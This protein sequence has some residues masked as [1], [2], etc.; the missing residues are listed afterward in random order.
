M[1][2]TRDRIQSFIDTLDYDFARFSMHEFVQWLNRRRGREIVRTPY[3][4]P[5]PTASGAWIAGEES[6]YIFYD[7]AASP[8][9]QTHIQLHEIAHMLRGH[10]TLQVG[11]E[12]VCMLFRAV[13]DSPIGLELLLS[14]RSASA[15]REAEMF[16]CLVQK[17]ALSPL[18]DKPKTLQ[19]LNH[20]WAEIAH[21]QE[22]AC[23]KT[24]VMPYH[25]PTPRDAT[26]DLDLYIYRAAIGILDGARAL[27]LSGMGAYEKYED[28]VGCCLELAS[29]RSN[30]GQILNHLRH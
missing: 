8:L 7:E 23:P 4:I 13:A 16:A 18:P 17:G 12:G 15:E 1:H 30:S 2:A 28:L 25:S 5:T 20:A 19:R 24:V 22:T 3:P 10:P 27:R 14:S 26:A 21:L 29:T 9:H 6:D 11:R